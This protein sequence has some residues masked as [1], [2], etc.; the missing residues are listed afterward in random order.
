MRLLF[1]LTLTLCL[2][3]GLAMAERL[4]S[5][6][7]FAAAPG[8]MP[9]GTFAFAARVND[10]GNPALAAYGLPSGTLITHVHM[11]TPSRI[12]LVDG[13]DG[14]I[15]NLVG[16]GPGDK[17]VVTGFQPGDTAKTEVTIYLKSAE[18]RLA[19]QK[20]DLIRRQLLAA[21]ASMEGGDPFGS[22]Y[23]G[24][25]IRLMHMGYFE[26]LNHL[27]TLEGD[28]WVKFGDQLFGETM[29]WFGRMFELAI[30]ADMRMSPYGGVIGAYGITRVAV[31]GDCGEPIEGLTSTRTEWT[32][33]RNGL[34]HYKGESSRATTTKQL[35]VPQGFG[36]VIIRNNQADVNVIAKMNLVPIVQRLGCAS[37]M[38]RRLEANMIAFFHRRKP[39]WQAPM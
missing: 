25:R 36:T 9:D 5:D 26:A 33:Y 22:S 2:S 7:D 23:W 32:E 21:Q 34:G 30:T 13:A 37:D 1:V 27:L 31:L 39:A 18:E 19:A 16:M 38:R 24:Y 29:P 11:I 28:Q 14:M 35:E 4:F 3:A 12:A 20:A 17:A 10:T 6:Q 15:E 8:I